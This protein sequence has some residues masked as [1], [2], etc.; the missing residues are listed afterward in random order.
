TM[1]AVAV[2][3]EEQRLNNNKALKPNNKT[4][5]PKTRKAILQRDQVCQYRSAHTGKIC[6]SRWHLQVD[7]KQPKWAGGNHDQE[8]LQ[9]LCGQ[10]N[11]RKYQKEAGVKIRF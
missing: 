7:H 11:R 4:L 5:T 9:V 8:N 6:G 10:H 1:A 2:E 3:S